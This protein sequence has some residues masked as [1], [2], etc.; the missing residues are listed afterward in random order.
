MI[1]FLA[2]TQST[3]IT[4]AGQAYYEQQIS[5]YVAE[6]RVSRHYAIQQFA[7]DG[8]TPEFCSDYLTATADLF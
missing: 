7:E 4:A 6:H 1:T 5:K 2:N 8:I 3:S